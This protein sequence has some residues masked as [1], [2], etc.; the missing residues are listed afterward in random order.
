MGIPYFFVELTKTY[1]NLITFLNKNKKISCDN[2]YIDFNGIIHV[3]SRDIVDD[4]IEKNNTNTRE[5]WDQIFIA[6]AKETLDMI[7]LANPRKLVYIAIDGVAP[8]AKM[9]H[10]RKRRFVSALEN[11]NRLRYFDSN[12]I[13]PRTKFMSELSIFVKS[14]L[15]QNIQQQLIFDDDSNCQEGEHKI[16]V[17]I[18]ACEDKNADHIINGLDGDII[19]LGICSR[20]KKVRILRENTLHYNK[21]ARY[22]TLN[23]HNLKENL[24]SNTLE[25]VETDSS[26]T[27]FKSRMLA[28]WVFM[29]FVLGNDFVPNLKYL[30]IAKNGLNHLQCIYAEKF[31]ESVGYL[32]NPKY[33]SSDLPRAINLKRLRSILEDV[34]EILKIESYEFKNWENSVEDP[35]TDMCGYYIKTLI[36]TVLYYFEGCKDFRFYYPYHYPP[37]IKNIIKYLEQPNFTFLYNFEARPPVDPLTQLL[38]ILPSQSKDLIPDLYSDVFKDKSLSEFFPDNFEIDTRN[39]KHSWQG[40]VLLPFIDISL[41]EKFVN[42]KEN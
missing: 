8:Y 16:L 24:Y 14:F 5:L 12:C 26:N 25:Q 31:N 37:T 23:V 29:N 3:I 32:I 13:S 33:L 41:V 39:C 40:K 10:Q 11:K 22:L 1:H 30:E 9:C 42:S 6:V 4:F 17:Y 28:D 35:Q 18:K 21:Q 27:L 38:C 7:K 15:E 36:W 20:A 19:V 34:E 2:F